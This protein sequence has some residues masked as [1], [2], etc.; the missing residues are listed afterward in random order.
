MYT[1]HGCENLLSTLLQCLWRYLNM[2]LAL[3]CYLTAEAR[4]GHTIASMAEGKLRTPIGGM[5]FAEER[6]SKGGW[7]GEAILLE[8]Y[9]VIHSELVTYRPIWLC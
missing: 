6:F 1:C 3:V 9:T 8:K 5:E 2:T 4:P 7:D